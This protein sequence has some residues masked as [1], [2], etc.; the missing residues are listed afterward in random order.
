MEH[1]CCLH[2]NRRVAEERPPYGAYWVLILYGC[3]SLPAISDA[4]KITINVGTIIHRLLGPANRSHQL[5]RVLSD[6][7]DHQGSWSARRP[8]SS[9]ACLQCNSRPVIPHGMPLA[10]VR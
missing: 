4:N 5:K 1:V 2:E 8:V 7:T 6:K 9:G 3:L 10:V